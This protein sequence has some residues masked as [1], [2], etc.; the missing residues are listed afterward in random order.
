MA[1]FIEKLISYFN[2]GKPVAGVGFVEVCVI[3]TVNAVKI[4]LLQYSC[5]FKVIKNTVKLLF[6]IFMITVVN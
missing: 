3:R 5:L 1:D 2:S 6:Y 4:P